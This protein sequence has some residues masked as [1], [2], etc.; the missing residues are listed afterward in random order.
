[1]N[2]V[3][4]LYVLNPARVA[5]GQVRINLTLWRQ[6]PTSCALSCGGHRSAVRPGAHSSVV[7]GAVLLG[8][9]LRG[10][11]LWM[12]FSLQSLFAFS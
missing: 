12:F 1:L 7:R 8:F 4:V 5:S 3:T 2:L 11:F 10:V 9:R 6:D